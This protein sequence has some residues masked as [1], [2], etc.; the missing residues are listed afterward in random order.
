MDVLREARA[1]TAGLHQTLTELAD[2]PRKA[3]DRL[4]ETLSARR[5]SAAEL[6]D[7]PPVVP[8]VAEGLR[9]FREKADSA[10]RVRARY[11]SWRDARQEHETHC[12]KQDIDPLTVS[13]YEPALADAR[14]VVA[15]ADAPTA[16]CTEVQSWLDDIEPPLAAAERSAS[17]RAQVDA[18]IA[19]LGDASLDELAACYAALEALKEQATAHRD[20]PILV[21]SER[22]HAGDA[23][24]KVTEHLRGY[25]MYREWE[26]FGE[27]KAA[28]KQAFRPSA[29]E[30][31]RV[32]ILRARALAQRSFVAPAH[33]EVARQAVAMD[34]LRIKVIDTCHA[35]R[36][37]PSSEKANSLCDELQRHR[38]AVGDVPDQPAPVT[39][40]ARRLRD[41]AARADAILQDRKRFIALRDDWDAHAR[42][43]RRRSRS[44]LL[45]GD[46]KRLAERAEALTESPTLASG[47]R[48]WLRGIVDNVAYPGWRREWL[49]H[50][51]RCSENDEHKF[52]TGDYA[53]LLEVAS[54][55]DRNGRL[56]DQARQFLTTLLDDRDQF[57]DVQAVYDE[58]WEQWTQRG[59]RS[60]DEAADAP[61]PAALVEDMEWLLAHHRH[62]LTPEQIGD[63]RDAVRKGGP[64]V[65]PP[66]PSP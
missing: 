7:S 39:G 8:G 53:R 54:E 37:E 9:E 45:G 10:L 51:E 1:A 56:P 41:A 2:A 34:D 21:P 65:Q 33:R 6:L 66:G 5:D 25:A 32:H 49:E 13:G 48:E 62:H 61:E 47:Y 44:P 64:G 63:L 60:A 36:R 35:I 23:V 55:L 19:E 52:R 18:T 22:Q 31:E 12:R 14:Q 42:R 30:A 28:A 59:R 17:C 58:V 11:T 15:A 3:M 26:R 43:Q 50:E 38:A 57:D 20:D 4:Y 16:L 24:D 46:A 29:R 40:H 27:E